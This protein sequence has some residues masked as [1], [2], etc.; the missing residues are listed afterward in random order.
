MYSEN[1]FER[2]LQQNSHRENYSALCDKQAHLIVWGNSLA[3]M[4]TN[5]QC[6]CTIFAPVSFFSILF[7]LRTKI[8]YQFQKLVSNDVISCDF[9]INVFPTV[10][11]WSFAALFPAFLL[12]VSQQAIYSFWQQT[13]L[14]VLKGQDYFESYR[15]SEWVRQLQA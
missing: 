12:F 5:N 10:H 7:F 6:F 2:K 14:P 9:H 3:E 11:S 15:K 1:C 8:V 13:K 4:T